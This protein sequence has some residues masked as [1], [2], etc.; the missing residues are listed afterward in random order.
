MVIKCIGRDIM[1]EVIEK[2]ILTN[3]D[4]I[5]RCFHHTSDLKFREIKFGL[6][7]TAL[8]VVYLEGIVDS[9]MLEESVINRIAEADKSTK[10][11]NIIDYLTKKILTTP[12][13][14]TVE[15]LKKLTDSLLNGNAV[16]IVDGF[17]EAIS[18]N[19][20]KWQE[21]SLEE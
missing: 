16:V 14:D 4:K 18:V 7:D 6:M 20:T 11:K 2:D 19:V 15:D 9:V 21:R 17:S 3:I 10:G 13:V 8:A 12:I 5:R 1:R